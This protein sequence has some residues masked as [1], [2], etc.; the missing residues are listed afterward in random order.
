MRQPIGPA[1]RGS[2]T[3]ICR[4]NR[5]AVSLFVRRHGTP[6][7]H[8]TS[9]HGKSPRPCSWHRQRHGRCVFAGVRAQPYGLHPELGGCPA[10]H[11]ISAGRGMRSRRSKAHSVFGSGGREPF[12]LWSSRGYGVPRTKPPQRFARAETKQKGSNV[13]MKKHGSRAGRASPR[14]PGVPQVQLP[15]TVSTSPVWSHVPPGTEAR[16]NHH[17]VAPQE[18]LPS[19]RSRISLGQSDPWIG[20]RSSKGPLLPAPK[21]PSSHGSPPYGSSAQRGKSADSRQ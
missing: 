9:T 18:Q 13:A 15:A 3:A 20:R 10:R 17:L 8:A 5:W 12:S 4:A 6:T 19:E 11:L 1:D 7:H 2:A 16:D 14:G 21:S